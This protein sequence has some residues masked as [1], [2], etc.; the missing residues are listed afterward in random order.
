M[1][2]TVL[3]HGMCYTMQTLAQGKHMRMQASPKTSANALVCFV[4]EICMSYRAHG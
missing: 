4:A 2:V 1:L 3:L